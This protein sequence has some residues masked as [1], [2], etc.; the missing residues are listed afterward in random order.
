[1]ENNDVLRMFRY[2]LNIPDLTMLNIFKIAECKID[3]Q[4]LLNLLKKREDEG[5]VACSTVL[6]ERFFN[7][8]IIYNRGRQG[9]ETSDPGEKYAERGSFI[10]SKPIGT[11]E[12]ETREVKNSQPLESLSNNTILKKIR[13]ALDLKQE[14][15]MEIFRLGKV[16]MTKGEF[17]ALFRK[18]GHKNYKEC[19]DQYLKKFLQGLAVR[20]RS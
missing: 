16:N 11:T 13:I 4:Q 14:E 20:H 15:M 3:G 18:E 12:R 8:L 19:G 6:L 10:E 7:G 2:A 17:T 9:Y 1:M 5:Y